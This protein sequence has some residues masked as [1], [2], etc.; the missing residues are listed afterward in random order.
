MNENIF[1][2]INKAALG[3]GV[4][5]LATLLGCVDRVSVRGH[6]GSGESAAMV[7]QDDYVY[8]PDYEVYYNSSRH[9]YRYRDG[10][11]WVTRSAPPRVSAQV[12]QAS[13]SVRMAF[14]DAPD[15]HH[16]QVAKTYPKGW[17]PT[18]KRQ[19]GKDAEKRQN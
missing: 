18:V 16:A 9:D 11:N 13:P 19:N 12:V 1:P 6:A 5:L 3:L 10:N 2:A 4:L 7:A 15:Q 8:Y 14:H 17:K